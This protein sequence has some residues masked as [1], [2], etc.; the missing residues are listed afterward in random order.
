MRYLLFLIPIFLYSGE[1]FAKV[2]PFMK[3][4][5]SSKVSG[6]VT[7]TNQKL[8][9]Q[10]AEDQTIIQI[11]DEVSKINYELAKSTYDI[12]RNFYHK[13]KRLTTKSKIEKD[14]EKITFLNAKQDYIRAKDDLQSRSIRANNLYIEDILV[15]KG[16]FVNPGTPL[17]KAYDISRAK[18]T[19][20]V[21][22]E[23]ILNI[24]NKQIIVNGGSDFKLLRYSKIT[25]S[26]QISSYKVELTGKSPTYFSQIAKVEIK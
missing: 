21:S 11:D 15:K 2:E 8:I 17:L 13:I 25:D 9:N 3:Y 16:N 23:D 26:I 7:K 1:Y 6:L 5:I 24:E 19:I 14:N 12:K 20:F 10:V 22:K 4:T 18:I